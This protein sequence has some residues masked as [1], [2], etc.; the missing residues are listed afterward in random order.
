MLPILIPNCC[1]KT[2]S[3][4]FPHCLNLQVLPRSLGKLS[5]VL[6]KNLSSAIQRLSNRTF[7]NDESVT[8][9]E[10][11]SFQFLFVPIYI[12]TCGYWS[13]KLYSAVQVDVSWAFC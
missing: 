7:C 13:H 10:D 1:F 4:P 3:L 9:T 11:L 5:H 12:A 6:W 8:K 2:S